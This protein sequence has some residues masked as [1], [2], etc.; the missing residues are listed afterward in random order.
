MFAVV[1]SMETESGYDS[2]INLNEHL[3]SSLTR[4]GHNGFEGIVGSNPAFR[5]VLDQIRTVAPTGST[6]LIEE[7]TGAGKVVVATATHALSN[8]RQ[9]PLRY[10]GLRGNSAGPARE[11]AIRPQKRPRLY[12][13]CDVKTSGR[14]EPANGGALFLD[15]IGDIPLELQVKVLRVLQE[16]EFE[17]LGC[18]YSDEHE[19]RKVWGH[20]SRLCRLREARFVSA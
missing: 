13:R 3:E 10:A 17:R 14:S 5:E 7:E 16:Q 8:R 6:V 15:E 19:G 11:C 9:W 1:Q 20:K 4:E 18:T 12:G 2:Y